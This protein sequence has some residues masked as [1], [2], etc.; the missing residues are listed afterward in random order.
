MAEQRLKTRPKASTAVRSI[1]WLD[2][3][4]LKSR[5]SNRSSSGECGSTRGDTCLW[6]TAW[7]D[8][9]MNKLE[10]LSSRELEA[11]QV[12][13]AINRTDTEIARIE[14][15]LAQMRAKQIARHRELVT[16]ETLMRLKPSNDKLRD[17]A[18]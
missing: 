9:N 6:P 17:A 4:K 16:Q 5:N 18:T 10:E 12:R 13:N 2:G 8:S 11:Q 7:K 1:S 14:G 15:V 3:S